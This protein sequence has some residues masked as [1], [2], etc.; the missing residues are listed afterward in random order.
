MSFTGLK[1]VSFE[2]PRASEIAQL[3]RKQGGEAIVAPSMREMPIERNEEAFRFAEPLLAGEF[4]QHLLLPRVGT[5]IHN[6]TLSTRYAPERLAGA[7]RRMAI[8][9]R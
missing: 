5:R 9:A 8:V 1:V 4:A 7:A 3:I 6:Q 2:S